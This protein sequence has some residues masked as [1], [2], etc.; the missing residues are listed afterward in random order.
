MSICILQKKYIVRNR[1]IRSEFRNGPLRELCLNSVVIDLGRLQGNHCNFFS[2]VVKSKFISQLHCQIMHLSFFPLPLLSSVA[3]VG[4]SHHCQPVILLYLAEGNVLPPS[5]S[6]VLSGSREFLCLLILII[7]SP[8]Y[9]CSLPLLASFIATF[10]L[11]FAVPF[12]PFSYSV[13][14]PNPAVVNVY[15]SWFTWRKLRCCSAKL[16]HCTF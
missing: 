10:P 13:K 11:A 8:V 3:P 4:F 9:S 5:L 14:F 15:T 16:S 2:W 6:P 1:R 7:D 12:Y